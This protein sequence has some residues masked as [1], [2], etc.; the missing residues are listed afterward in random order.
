MDGDEEKLRGVW[1]ARE[2]VACCKGCD[3][4]AAATISVFIGLRLDPFVA[5]LLVNNLDVNI[6]DGLCLFEACLIISIF[7]LINDYDQL[8]KYYLDN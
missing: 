4:L 1:L 2:V 6:C 3:G 5:G 8:F 7:L